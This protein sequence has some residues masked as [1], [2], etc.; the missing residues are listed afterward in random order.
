MT[1][2]AAPDAA[3]AALAGSSGVLEVR[4]VSKAFPNVQALDDVSLDVR[5]GE[6]LAFLRTGPKSTLLA[7]LNGDYQ[8]DEGTLTIDGESGFA[9]PREARAAGIRVIYQEPETSPVSTSPRTSSP[10]NCPAAAPSST[11]GAQPDRR[12]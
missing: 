8:P 6:V 2:T 11:P 4:H 1:L 5:P 3:A 9:N 7:I 12:P 10:A